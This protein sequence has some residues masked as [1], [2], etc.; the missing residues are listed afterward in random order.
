MLVAGSI[1]FDNHK[2]HSQILKQL[3]KEA[4]GSKVKVR[5]EGNLIIYSYIDYEA[6]KRNQKVNY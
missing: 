1:P 4:K 2:H 5:N 6:K 3:Y